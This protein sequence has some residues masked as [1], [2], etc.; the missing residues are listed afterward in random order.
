[1][2]KKEDEKV[3]I[4]VGDW[5]S[6]HSYPESRIAKAVR[7]MLP[8]NKVLVKVTKYQSITPRGVYPKTLELTLT[9]RKRRR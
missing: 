7:R 8:P 4:V 1:M 5:Y 3:R 2:V 9:T 6:W